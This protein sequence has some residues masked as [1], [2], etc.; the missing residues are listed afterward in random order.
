MPPRLLLDTH[1]L[2][3]WLVE[4]K[5]LS[6]E[7]TRA[8]EAAMGRGEPVA[9]SA[10]TLIE[11]SM[12]VSEGRL[13]LNRPTGEFLEALAENPAISLFP[14]TPRVAAEAASLGTLRDAADR[15][16]VGTARAHHLRVVTSDQRII[17]AKLVAVVE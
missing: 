15:T 14:L 4:P 8:I 1:V 2:I 11:V 12:L 6:R 13:R 3:R 17:D 5:L 9:I 10:I 16:I 7:Q